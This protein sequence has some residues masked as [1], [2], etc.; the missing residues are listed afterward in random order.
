MAGGIK[1]SCGILGYQ[2]IVKKLFVKIKLVCH[3]EEKAVINYS[4]M[5]LIIQA[6]FQVLTATCFCLSG[7]T[8][9]VKWFISEPVRPLLPPKPGKTKIC[10]QILSD[11]MRGVMEYIYGIYFKMWSL[12]SGGLMQIMD[13]MKEHRK[14]KQLDRWLH[15]TSINCSIA[16]YRKEPQ[17]EPMWDKRHQIFHLNM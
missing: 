1:Y 7:R 9:W 14:G 2:Y 15:R 10:S 16:S 5:L 13:Y 4:K 11:E 6:N 8:L 12:I 17:N 3:L